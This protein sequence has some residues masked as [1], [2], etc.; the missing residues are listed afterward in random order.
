MTPSALRARGLRKSFGG[1]DAVRGVGI[2]LAAGRVHALLG[3][4][5]AGKS[6]LVNM[7][8]G[9][10]EPDEG[11][12]EI[13]GQPCRL[14]SPMVAQS[15][16]IRTVHQELEV[17]GQLTVAENV[18]M[19]RLPCRAGLVQASRLRSATRSIL[20]ELGT[21]LD[22]DRRL[23]S[24]VVAD[25]QLVEIARALA[26]GPRVLFLDEPTA[27]LTPVEAETLL[28]RLRG[29]AA[30]GVAILYIS[31]RLDEVFAVANEIT[32][33]RDGTVAAHFDAEEADRATVVRAMLGVELVDKEPIVAD[34]TG[35]ELI[36]V[37]G[38]SAGSLTKA[39]FHLDRGEVVGFF[40]LTGSGHDMVAAS[41]FGLTSPAVDEVQFL[42]SADLPATPR[43]AL[44]R[45]VGF[46]PSD[47][48]GEGLALGLP[49]AD[50]LLMSSRKR[51]SRFGIRDATA[52]RAAIGKLVA[53]Y[54]I[55]VASPS[56]PVSSLSGG[57]Q[58][59][60]VLARLAARG[61]L[62]AMV[63]CEP[64]RGV[65]VGAKA[66]IYDHLRAFVDAGRTAM[67]VSSD[68]DEIAAV[69]DRV[70][71]VRGGDIVAELPHGSFTPSSLT[72]VAL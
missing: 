58:Q 70:Y 33:M 53:Q 39:D 56:A 57:N 15:F 66:E 52:E 19:G 34:S 46:V 43:D 28:D 31:H 37:R 54:Q 61:D 60:V 67:I 50:N 68:A 18:F 16:G 55:K 63:L 69:C 48:K 29:L 27:A 8:S 11:S 40:G 41:M 20:S 62:K 45:G 59:K 38:L 30:S 5:G 7:L 44:A 13:G 65:D 32:V 25:R 71:V 26:A 47:R 51:L 49:I 2:E 36:S 12:I 14:S 6:T 1:V 17:A 24:L 35:E 10:F 9:I 64:T 72:A 42:G 23:D 4:N 21:N 22:P 3:E